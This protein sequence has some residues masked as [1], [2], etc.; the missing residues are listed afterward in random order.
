MF[1]LPARTPEQPPIRS[2]IM[3]SPATELAGERVAARLG[4]STSAVLTGIVAAVLGRLTGHDRV[5]LLL[6]SANRFDARRRSLVAP[7]VQDV[8]CLVD[9]T[10]DLDTVIRET[11]R[12][13]LLAHANACYD[14][15]AE[16]AVRR[17]A[18]LARDVCFDFHAAIVNDVRLRGSGHTATAGPTT[19]Q[20]GA[21]WDR[22]NTRF[23]VRIIR[24]DT[25]RI[26]LMAD[27]RYVADLRTVLT[28][29]ESVALAAAEGVGSLDDVAPLP[30]GGSWV[31]CAAGWVDT[32]ALAELMRG[33]PW[34]VA[35]D[36]GMVDGELTAQVTTELPAAE[37]RAAVRRA[38]AMLN[39]YRAVL[40]RPAARAFC[41][42]GFVGRLPVAMT[43]VAVV[44]LA[45]DATGSYAV[46]GALN[47][48]AICCS[49]AAGPVFGRL[50]DRFGQTKVLLPLVIG[51]VAALVGQVL[52]AEGHAPAV[53]LY[54]SSVPVGALTP[55]IGA[56]TRARWSVL[57]T[58]ATDLNRAYALES[59][60][61]DVA[62]TLGPVL[63]TTLCLWHASAGLLTA[64]AV[65]LV[66][67]TAFALQ[68]RTIPAPTPGVRR[69]LLAAVRSA[70]SVRLLVTV[71]GVGTMLGTLNVSLVAF[72][73]DRHVAGAAGW[74]IGGFAA[75][76]MV[77]GL[78]IGQRPWRRDPAARYRLAL[79]YLAVVTVPL[80]LAPSVPAMA[81]A[82]VAAGSGVSPALVAAY[83]TTERAAPPGALAETLTWTVTALTG[84][85][86]AGAAVSGWLVDG[87]DPRLGLF[88]GTVAAWLAAAVLVARRA[89]VPVKSEVDVPA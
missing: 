43:G 20:D 24:A 56:F 54:L 28:A 84:G 59:V 76:S 21:S 17:A 31:R 63:G 47:A 77:V 30:R 89:P 13:T 46:A 81:I 75:A 16:L 2:L 65:E 35:A 18:E 62:F 86:A 4:V 44:F 51:H 19:F 37:V 6:I 38:P 11:A 55:T 80:P 9:L 40:A 73:Q 52:A 41:A 68:R 42:T 88:A 7:L 64:A 85:S 58:G 1:D 34:C 57:L 33:Q 15:A 50:V 3:T 32:T 72:T 8:L 53:V 10:G 36:V 67:G 39:G 82:V 71:F 79:L 70:E 48:I 60:L 14:P 23:F 27:T 69:R 78:A 83:T 74:L 25:C 22:Q 61:D 26:E 87:H 29:I 45:R 49:A 66:S 5:T 12:R